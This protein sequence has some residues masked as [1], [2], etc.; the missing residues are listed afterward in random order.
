MATDRMLKDTVTV[1]VPTG[2]NDD[3]VMQY[4]G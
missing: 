4:D 2:E 3:G 1:F